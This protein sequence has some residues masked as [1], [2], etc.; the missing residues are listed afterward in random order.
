MPDEGRGRG[1]RTTWQ[2]A[3]CRRP[4]SGLMVVNRRSGPGSRS[5]SGAWGGGRARRSRPVVCERV[6]SGCERMAAASVAVQGE[7][8]DHARSREG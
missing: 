4:H 6:S 1:L 5:I 7:A 3:S 8:V 2:K